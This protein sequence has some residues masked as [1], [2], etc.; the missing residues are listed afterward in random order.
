LAALRLKRIYGAMEF[1]WDDAKHA[2]TLRERGLGFDDAARIFDGP[3]VI[4]QDRRRDYGETR[5]Q[6]VGETEGDVLHVVFTWRG[7]IMRI[8]SVRRANRKEV[9]LWRLRG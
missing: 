2:R 4:R 9:R 5:F 8:I 7:A 3:V 1:E 6:A